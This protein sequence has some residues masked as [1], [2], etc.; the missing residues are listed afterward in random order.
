MVRDLS[1]QLNGFKVGRQR[2]LQPQQNEV[3]L[4]VNIFDE[5]VGSTPSPPT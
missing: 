1:N 5:G 3:I 2:A 4:S